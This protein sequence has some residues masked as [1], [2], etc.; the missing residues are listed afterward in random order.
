M[1]G[2]TMKQETLPDWQ[3]GGQIALAIAAFIDVIFPIIYQY[4]NV[5][6]EDSI[7]YPTLYPFIYAMTVAGPNAS[8]N[9]SSPPYVVIILSVLFTIG[10]Y[11]SIGSVVGLILGKVTNKN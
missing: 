1:R 5:N 6:I 4:N 3:K 9:L 2:K 8:A 10:I 7:L 11:F